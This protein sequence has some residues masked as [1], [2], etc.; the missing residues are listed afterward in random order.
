MTAGT[1]LRVGIVGT[2]LI[3][4]FT[5]Q[6]MTASAGCRP[7]AVS[8]R[9]MTSAQAFAATQGFT[10]AFDDWRTLLASPDIDAV[11]VATPTAPREAICLAAACQGKHVLA[12]KPFASLASVRAITAACREAGVAFMDATHFV[13]HPRT[14]ALKSLLAQRIG[15]VQAV[16][17]NFF[18]PNNDLANVRFDPNQEPMGAI[19]DMAWY[20]M[21]AMAEFAAPQ[22]TLRHS[23]GFLQRDRA[24]GAAVRGAGVMQLSDG[25]T[26]TWDVGYN[27]GACT[28]DLQLLGEHGVVTLDD[29]VLDWAQ[30]FMLPRPGTEA[31]FSLRAGVVNPDGYEWV[32]TASNQPQSVLMVDA[33]AALAREPRGAAAAASRL[34][35]ERTQALLDGA[36]HSLRMN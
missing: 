13:H 34:A 4:G 15:P 1:A 9:S 25:C 27:C 33:F 21:R 16:R 19:G 31:G 7:V 22:A 10:A 17:S 18:F 32:S 12:E 36:W 23:S 2:G 6:T 11:Y 5:A 28:M 30:G 26:A 8:S 3:A 24:S 20:S 35:S 14:A 29:F